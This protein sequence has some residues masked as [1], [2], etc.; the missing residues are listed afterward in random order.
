MTARVALIDTN[1]LVY[2]HDAG[3][4]AKQ[5]KALQVLERL[6]STGGGV[7]S[8]QCLVE[9]VRAV[10]KHASFRLTFL[11]AALL[12]EHYSAA[13]QV[14]PV[15]PGTV[16]DACHA[17]AAFPVSLWDALIWAV[18]RAN[19]V[20]VILT[21]DLQHRPDIE[22]IRYLNPFAPDFDLGVLG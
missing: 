22:G 5:R 17:A 1:V 6:A 3:D 15:T 20:P 8:S 16:T 11:N 14:Y 10:T 19:R 18:A 7:L 9:F 13:Y 12:V 4:R 21:E 2:A